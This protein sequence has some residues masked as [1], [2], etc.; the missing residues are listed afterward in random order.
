MGWIAREKRRNRREIVRIVGGEP[1]DPGKPTDIDRN[2]HRSLRWVDLHQTALLSQSANKT[3]KQSA[4]L[5]GSSA[6]SKTP[7]G[8]VAVLASPL[9]YT[10][11]E[12]ARY[13]GPRADCVAP[14]SN[15]PDFAPHRA[16]GAQGT[17]RCGRHAVHSRPPRRGLCAVWWRGAPRRSRCDA[18]PS[19]RAGNEAS[20]QT[21]E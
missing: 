13:R 10:V 11:L 21:A 2:A 15:I 9:Y 3:V 14:R 5:C 4:A 18:G 1:S 20:P 7:A 17:P 8:L 6:S 12:N 16:Q 19:P